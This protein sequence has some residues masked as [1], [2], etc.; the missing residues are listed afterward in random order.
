MTL[1]PFKRLLSSQKY[2]NRNT[3]SK[4]ALTDFRKK[5]LQRIEIKIIFWLY[6]EVTGHSPEHSKLWIWPISWGKDMVP[7]TA[8]VRLWL[9]RQMLQKPWILQPPFSHPSG[10][11]GPRNH[12]TKCQSFPSLRTRC[13]SSCYTQ[14]S[15]LWVPKIFLSSL[16]REL[17]MLQA[18]WASARKSNCQKL[19]LMLHCNHPIRLHPEV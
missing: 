3:W 5:S 12:T 13:L 11:C 6:L 10:Q 1:V 2:T 17:V 19:L 16:D 14:S 8:S 9:R 15:I 18:A 7:E 4:T